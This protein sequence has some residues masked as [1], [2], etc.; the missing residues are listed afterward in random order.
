M[1]LLILR[2]TIVRLTIQIFIKKY[3]NSLLGNRGYYPSYTEELLK[4]HV[5]SN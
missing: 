5:G 1:N 3:K 4:R 2:W